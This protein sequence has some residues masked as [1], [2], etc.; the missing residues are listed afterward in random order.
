[1][2]QPDVIPVM[3]VLLFTSVAVAGVTMFWLVVSWKRKAALGLTPWRKARGH[4]QIHDHPFRY[5]RRPEAW[6]AIHKRTLAEVQTALSLDGVRPAVWDEDPNDE[7][8]L[9]IMPP[10]EGWT[11]VFGRGLPDPAA[12]VDACFRFLTGLSR[13]LG[14][15]QFFC[16]DTALNHHAWA[17]LQGGHVV[18]AYA[19]AGGTVWNQG[20]ATPAE[21][22][23]GLKC[24]DYTDGVSRSKWGLT[25][26]LLAN[27]E[28]VPL[29]AARWSLDPA[30]I[31]DQ[32]FARAHGIAGRPSRR[33]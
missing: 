6:L 32:T 5:P 29:L 17:R 28:K 21:L 27:V 13:Q 22:E 3:L 9:F 20:V 24:F 26:L 31:D 10:V 23:L 18:R 15:V 7:R 14:Q 16:A 19:W 1:M 12:D 11:F 4:D 8:T 25:D 2:T 33:Y 30:D